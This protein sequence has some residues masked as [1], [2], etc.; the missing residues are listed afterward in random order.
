MTPDE[1]GKHLRSV[2]FELRQTR[3]EVKR[4]SKLQERWAER[5]TV[6]DNRISLIESLLLTDPE[7]MEQLGD[8]NE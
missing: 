2:L 5:M 1:L 3:Q 8:N 6:L 4:L 7:V